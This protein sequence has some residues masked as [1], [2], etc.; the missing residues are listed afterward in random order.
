MKQAMLG[1]L[2]IMERTILVNDAGYFFDFLLGEA[3]R[4]LFVKA[5]N[6]NPENEH[7]QVIEYPS[8]DEILRNFKSITESHCI[9]ILHKPQEKEIGLLSAYFKIKKLDF[10]RWDF[11][12]FIG[13]PAVDSHKLK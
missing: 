7:M 11:L 3:D 10:R 8:Y 6:I 12:R 5:G 13:A 9:V 1:E 4:K 2:P